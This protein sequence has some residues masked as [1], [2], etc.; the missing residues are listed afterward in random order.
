[1]TVRKRKNYPG[2]VRTPG[3]KDYGLIL[4]NLIKYR[5]ELTSTDDEDRLYLL[6]RKVAEKLQELG[7][8]KASTS[9]KRKT[10]NF[11]THFHKR[12]D[13]ISQIAANKW[14]EGKTSHEEARRKIKEL[15]R[16]ERTALRKARKQ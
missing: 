15:K 2:D 5:N 16:E 1:M 14:R 3:T 6:Y 11:T 4:S 13:E 8:T 10:K 12:K 9:I 7:F